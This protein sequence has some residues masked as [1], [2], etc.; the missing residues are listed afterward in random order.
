MSDPHDPP[1]APGETG[2]LEPA[3]PVSARYRAAAPAATDPAAAGGA[4]LGWG[5]MSIGLAGVVLVAVAAVAGA[6]FWAPLLP[7]AP[8]PVP[9]PAATDA[10]PAG[11]VE[12]TP[13]QPQIQAATQPAQSQQQS[14]SPQGQPAQ[15]Q[16]P[17]SRPEEALNEA[18]Q[19]L[20]RRVAALEV[21]PTV[22]VSDIADTR[23][24]LARLAGTAANLDARVA[25]LGKAA[26]PQSA[27][28]TTD[29][30]LVLALLQIRGALELG[31]PFAAEYEALSGLARAR[32][33]IAAAAAAL[34]GPAKTGLATR[35][36]LANRLHELAGSIA[37]AGARL[38]P[39]ADAARSLPA[40]AK[41][42]ASDWADRALA[43]LRGLV[44][45]RRVDG[46]GERSVP[47]GAAAPVNAAER[48]L[49]GGDLDGAVGALDKLTGAPAEAARP[50]LRM[51]N[52]RLAAEAALYR[53]EA[54][55]VARLGSTPSTP[56]GTRPDTPGGAGSPR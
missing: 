14:E 29:V 13:A 46:V 45:I 31:R 27:A 1:A 43:R 15:I 7:W 4:A 10:A 41:P 23:Q 51:A 11:R 35:A 3:A 38:D 53:I 12:V 19:R 56:P 52:E 37:A 49:A 16:P 50:W 30:A 17:V 9:V 48:A 47:E 44:T 26:P 34:A 24:Q 8:A 55:L 25:A 5:R 18:L 22:P 21:R 40:V 36:V 33:E 39:P 32:P 20:D 6:P 2:A 28:D 42:T 54:L